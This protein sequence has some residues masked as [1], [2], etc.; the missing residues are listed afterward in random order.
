MQEQGK[1]I[2]LTF[3]SERKSMFEKDFLGIETLLNNLN[4][5]SVLSGMLGNNQKSSGRNAKLRDKNQSKLQ[6]KYNLKKI[7]K[8]QT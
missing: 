8:L 2:H 1:F 4:Q 5:N 6:K 3:S 7:I